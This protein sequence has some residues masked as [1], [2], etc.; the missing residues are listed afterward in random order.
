MT[1]QLRT[2]KVR[3]NPWIGHDTISR[4]GLPIGRVPVEQP[5]G[6]FDPRCVGVVKVTAI[7]TSAAPK[8]AP[9]A[10]ASHDLEFEYSKEPVSVANTEYYRRRVMCGDLIAADRPS[11]LASGGRPKDYEEHEKLLELCKR[12]AIVEFDVANGEGAFAAL[13]EQRVEDE[14]RRAAIAKAIANGEAPAA[15]PLPAEA[16]KA[17]SKKADA[18]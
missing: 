14:K 12:A 18:K 2:L 10:Q 17:E 3:P 13:N 1:V 6:L 4:T 15:T 7:Q 11:F 5:H 8:G 9:L 16:T